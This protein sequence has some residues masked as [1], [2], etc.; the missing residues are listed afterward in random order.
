M[1]LGRDFLN[2]SGVRL[3]SPQEKKCDTSWN[4]HV[5]SWEKE[6][7]NFDVSDI[8]GASN[9]EFNINNNLSFNLKQ[10]LSTIL[11]NAIVGNHSEFI[12]NYIKLDIKLINSQPFYCAPR[13]LPYTHKLELK[14][15]IKTTYY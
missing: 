1:I 10:K 3:I 15:I 6:I 9:C 2:Y 5:E 4:N 14:K 13:R 11:S 12:E 7:L 8:N